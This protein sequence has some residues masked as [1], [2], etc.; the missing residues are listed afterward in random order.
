L[1]AQIRTIVR[2]HILARLQN[3][4]MRKKDLARHFAIALQ[5]QRKS[6]KVTQQTLAERADCDLTMISLIERNLRNPSINLAD[7]LAHGLGIP[8]WELIKEAEDL[9]QKK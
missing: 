8:L 5:R 1:Q 7:S 2:F 6:R 9:R 3:D 4:V